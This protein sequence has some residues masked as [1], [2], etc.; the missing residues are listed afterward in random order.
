MTAWLTA[1]GWAVPGT[2]ATLTRW[3]RTPARARDVSSD[4]ADEA[5]RSTR[6]M[7]SGPHPH[8]SARLSLWDQVE[9]LS[10]M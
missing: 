1:V 7:P 10:R 9:L 2:M 8:A 4:A 5:P 3:V 6:A